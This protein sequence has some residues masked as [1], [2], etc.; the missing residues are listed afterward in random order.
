ME[1]DN[2]DL[3]YTIGVDNSETDSYTVISDN[4]I[5]PGT[6][7][8]HQ[9]NT[10]AFTFTSDSDTGFYRGGDRTS[11]RKVLVKDLTTGKSVSGRWIEESG[12]RIAIG[13]VAY[14]IGTNLGDISINREEKLEVPLEGYDQFFQTGKVYKM[15]KG[16]EEKLFTV[17]GWGPSLNDKIRI[18]TKEVSNLEAIEIQARN[19]DQRI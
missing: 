1:T 7:F 15:Q 16:K 19:N 10:P 3:Q 9:G 8:I 4:A 12:I 13:G 17:E 11:R 2:K 5:P 18:H 14:P 6:F